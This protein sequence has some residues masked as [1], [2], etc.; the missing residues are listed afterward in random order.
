MV[1]T[2]TKI[3]AG[4]AGGVCLLSVFVFVGFQ[5]LLTRH[6]ST[7]HSQE[8]KVFD[9]KMRDNR[10]AS[11]E[12]LVSET[13]SERMAL[14]QLVL[15]DESV[16]EFLSLIESLGKGQGITVKTNSIDVI[17]NK[18]SFETLVLN[19]EVE[20]S[21]QGVL[22]ILQLLEALPYKSSVE[23]VLLSRA[24]NSETGNVWKGVFVLHVTKYKKI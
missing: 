5:Y 6:E 2:R 21:E 20:G 18:A 23:S 3:L 19:L 17:T 24:G 9:A 16:V 11:M 8:K 13:E 12:R 15:P 10:L 1:H 4:I 7:L 22:H 14:A